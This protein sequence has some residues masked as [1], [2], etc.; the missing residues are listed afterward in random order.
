MSCSHDRRDGSLGHD[1]KQGRRCD[2]HEADG[3]HGLLRLLASGRP[4]RE[5]GGSKRRFPQ[6]RKR[7][8]VNGRICDNIRFKTEDETFGILD[9]QLIFWVGSGWVGSIVDRRLELPNHFRCAHVARVRLCARRS[10]LSA[11][12]GPG[13]W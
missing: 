7:E 5:R 11:E 1:G 13:A 3:Q 4:S 6:V 8:C 9:H 10:G 12:E 2:P